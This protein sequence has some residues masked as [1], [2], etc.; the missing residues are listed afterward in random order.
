MGGG[1]HP[2]GAREEITT[3]HSPLNHEENRGPC[4]GEVAMSDKKLLEEIEE[5]AI[6]YSQQ[7]KA[8]SQCTLLALQEVF[9][10]TNDAV[11]K[12][13]SGFAGG[14]G[15]MGSVCGALSGGVMALGLLYGRDEETMKHP[16]EAVRSQRWEEIEGKL[17]ILIKKL[18]SK[19]EEEY[20]TIICDDIEVKLFGRSFDKWNPEE[21][22]EKAR[23]GG[24][25]GKCPTVVGNAARWTAEL[26]ME[27]RGEK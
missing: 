24:Y 16:D 22:D 7:Y 12:A 17:C 20:G 4:I 10:L 6:T 15:R 3:C 1:A 5:R 14:I 8:C 27:E 13:S 19:F 9:G 25:E 2:G 23:L 26:I 21:R 11:L 18:R